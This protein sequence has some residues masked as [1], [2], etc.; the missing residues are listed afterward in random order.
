MGEPCITKAV[1][2]GACA[3]RVAPVADDEE[4]N[5]ELDDE[6]FIEEPETDAVGDTVRS[7]A[8]A[9]DSVPDPLPG[10]LLLRSLA[11]LAAIDLI[12]IAG[13]YCKLNSPN[14]F[15]IPYR[16]LE[17]NLCEKSMNVSERIPQILSRSTRES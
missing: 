9:V 1:R 12:S 4:L 14:S 3:S 11:L 15:W 7:I 17:G 5:E 2:G 10:F 16:T 6:Y 8:A 13:A